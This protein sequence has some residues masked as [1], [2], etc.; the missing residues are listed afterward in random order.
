MVDIHSATAVI[1]RGK[2]RKKKGR[3]KQDENIMSASST[4]GGHNYRPCMLSNS[5]VSVSW[6]IPA[7]FSEILKKFLIAEVTFTITQG[8]WYIGVFDRLHMIS[9]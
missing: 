3:K 4:Q 2:R 1:K 5:F 9:Y 8:H 6:I 7:I